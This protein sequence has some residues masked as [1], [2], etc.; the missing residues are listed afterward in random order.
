[1]ALSNFVH[2]ETIMKHGSN[3]YSAVLAHKLSLITIIPMYTMYLID[4]PGQLITV[5]SPGRLSRSLVREGD[6]ANGRTHAVL[7]HLTIGHLCHFIKI[8]LR[9]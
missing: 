5:H 9:T 6:V 3:R 1:M 7:Y 2:N 4:H 8:I